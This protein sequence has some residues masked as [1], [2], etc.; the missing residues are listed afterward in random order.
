MSATSNLSPLR[1]TNCRMLQGW[2]AGHPCHVKCTTTGVQVVPLQALAGLNGHPYPPACLTILRNQFVE[3]L[4]LDA[5]QPTSQ[6]PQQTVQFSTHLQGA[7]AAQQHQQQSCAHIAMLATYLTASTA[8]N[9]ALLVV[10]ESDYANVGSI[11]V[12]GSE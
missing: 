9:V 6:L 12:L 3:C 4:C 5:C 10:L 8:N 11:L 1:V 7:V 2:V